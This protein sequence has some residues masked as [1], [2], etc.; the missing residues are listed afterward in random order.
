MLSNVKELI[1]SSYFI[2]PQPRVRP[3]PL[4]SGAQTRYPAFAYKGIIF[5]QLYAN[6]GKPCRSRTKGFSTSSLPAS[7]RCILKPFELSTNRE[8]TPSGRVEDKKGFSS[9]ILISNRYILLYASSIAFFI[10]DPIRSSKPI[11]TCG[12][13]GSEIVLFASHS[14]IGN[15]PDTYSY[16][17]L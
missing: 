3:Y 5:R 8:V 7:K 13:T 17:S 4:K 11:G 2:G 14:A 12:A 6:S 1:S 9:V 10:A 15:C 16:F